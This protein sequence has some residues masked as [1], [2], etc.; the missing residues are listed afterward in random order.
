MAKVKKNIITQGLAGK[1]GD[2][3]V[4]RQ[5]GGKTIV[6]A[7]PEKRKQEL[8]EGQKKQINKFREA[9][10]YAKQALENDEVRTAY[11]AKAKVGQTAYNVAIADYMNA[12]VI[13]AIDLSAFDG[14][15]GRQLRIAFDIPYYI[16]NKK[17]KY[18]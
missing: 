16:E 7:M 15:K 14:K 6:Q 13:E 2:T 3:I 18:K 12:P 5:L 4:F 8:S 1:L 9:A 10:R 17:V 11:A